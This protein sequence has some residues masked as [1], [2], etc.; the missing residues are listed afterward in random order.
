MSTT[1]AGQLTTDYRDT[2]RQS[3]IRWAE[4]IWGHG[5]KIEL[6]AQNGYSI[7]FQAFPEYEGKGYPITS[8]QVVWVGN[9]TVDA[10]RFEK[11]ARERLAHAHRAWS[12]SVTRLEKELANW[13]RGQKAAQASQPRPKRRRK[14]RRKARIKARIKSRVL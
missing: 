11:I 5:V 9:G 8:P 12:T 7:L 10:E 13:E 6:Y 3:L 14:T 4:E 2:I 1:G